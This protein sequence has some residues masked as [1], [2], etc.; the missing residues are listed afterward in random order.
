MQS[1][2]NISSWFRGTPKQDKSYENHPNNFIK[3]KLSQICD[4]DYNLY[5]IYDF[6]TITKKWFETQITNPIKEAVNQYKRTPGQDSN[7]QKKKQRQQQRQQRQQRQKNKD[8]RSNNSLKTSKNKP[9][10]SRNNNNK[11]KNNVSDDDEE[12]KILTLWQ[13]DD[14]NDDEEMKI[15]KNSSLKKTRKQKT[16]KHTATMTN[17]DSRSRRTIMSKNNKKNANQKREQFI[18]MVKEDFTLFMYNIAIEEMEKKSS[19]KNIPKFR[20]WKT[21]PQFGTKNNN[22]KKNNNEPGIKVFYFDLYK[23]FYF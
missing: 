22:N 5:S 1:T 14:N 7:A 3:R 11:N 2:S 13:Y 20:G 12:M 6:R 4:G 16:K 8:L 21:E 15:L 23:N 9:R 17:R 10:L 19:I 18:L